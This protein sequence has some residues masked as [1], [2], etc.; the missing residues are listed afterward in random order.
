MI[1]A[2]VMRLRRL[3]DVALRTRA[4]A[5]ALDGG[6][7]AG[8]GD[9]IY[10]RTAIICWR[11]AGV[12]TGRLRAHPYLSYQ[13]GASVTRM[14]RDRM[15]AAVLGGIARHRGRGL[16]TFAVQLRHLER[17]LNDSR[18]LTWLLELSDALGRSQA[19]LR[20]LMKEV[21]H[22]AWKEAGSPVAVH[23]TERL[24]AGAREDSDSLAG[25]WPYLA[26]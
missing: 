4:F 5:V 25:T 26:F 1:D 6:D 8:A 9:S 23:S 13:R 3:R 19:R 15:L 20:R 18:A 16:R 21:D 2:E 22:G 12:A 14:I 17:E 24:A 7:A 11:I 10:A